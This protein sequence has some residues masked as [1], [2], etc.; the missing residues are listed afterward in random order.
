MANNSILVKEHVVAKTDPSDPD[1]VEGEVVFQ[2]DKL[3]WTQGVF[4]FR[5]HH[6]GRHTVMSI[7]EPFEIR[8]SK[9]A[10]EDVEVDV[11]TKAMY[12]KA[13]ESSLLPVIQNC[14]DRDDDIAPST[15][16]ESFG[17][18]V[19]RDGK[20]AK[21]I[22][23]AIREMFGVEFAPAVVLADRNVRK[24]AWR[25]CNAKEVL[26]SHFTRFTHSVSFLL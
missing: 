4:E 18:H 7:S 21:R 20:Y 2:G 17:S 3:W 1:V 5:Y 14:L 25:I 11:G 9:F 24:L 16:D 26:V 6:D 19:E 13:I 10:E 8:I 12:A 22:V 15:V 23:Y